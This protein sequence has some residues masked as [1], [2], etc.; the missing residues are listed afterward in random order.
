MNLCSYVVI[1]CVVLKIFVVFYLH[2]NKRCIVCRFFFKNAWSTD[3]HVCQILLLGNAANSILLLYKYEHYPIFF[4][5]YLYL[6]VQ[7]DPILNFFLSWTCL[8]GS[9]TSH[10][11]IFYLF[12]FF[13]SSISTW[14]TYKFAD[15]TKVMRAIK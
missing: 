2:I 3:S 4:T 15:D 11:C 9:Q 5:Y 13:S 12:L 6:M 14:M 1:F 10:G 8:L 7:S